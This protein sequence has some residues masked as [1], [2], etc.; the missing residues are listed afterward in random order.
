MID[1]FYLTKLFRLLTWSFDQL[2]QQTYLASKINSGKDFPRDDEDIGETGFCRVVCRKQKPK[3]TR[4]QTYASDTNGIDDGGHGDEPLGSA[5]FKIFTL[6]PSVHVHGGNEQERSGETNAVK[7]N[8]FGNFAGRMKL[9][10]KAAVGFSEKRAKKKFE[11]VN[12]KQHDEEENGIE[13]EGYAVL[14][15][16]ATEELIVGVPKQTEQAKTNRKRDKPTDRDTQLTKVFRKLER[17]DEQSKSKAKDYVAENFQAREES[18]AEAE[19]IFGAL[20][21]MRGK[22]R[23]AEES[24]YGTGTLLGCAFV[25]AFVSRL[26]TEETNSLRVM[27]IWPQRRS[28]SDV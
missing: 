22:H 7:Q 6:T 25:F 14:H 26:R 15:R 13:H 10:R 4:E 20:L 24:P 16:I 8:E 18:S 17:D 21:G 3:R 28:L 12:V 1:T 19:A 27:P 11:R 23:V 9:R 2:F 5:E